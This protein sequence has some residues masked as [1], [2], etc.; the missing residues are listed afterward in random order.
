MGSMPKALPVIDA[1]APLCCAPVAAA[2]MG[3]DAAL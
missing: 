3:A 1:T 2:P